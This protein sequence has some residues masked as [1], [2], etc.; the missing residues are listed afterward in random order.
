MRGLVGQGQRAGVLGLALNRP[1]TAV[2][3]TARHGEEVTHRPPRRTRHPGRR[4]GA[5]ADAFDAAPP[6]GGEQ[7]A[8]TVNGGSRPDRRRARR[9]P[10]GACS[11]RR[12]AWGEGPRRK[13]L[14]SRCRRQIA[15]V[16]RPSPGS[17]TWARA[18]KVQI[19]GSLARA[20][21]AARRTPRHRRRPSHRPPA[22]PGARGRA[23][24]RAR[25]PPRPR[26][27]WRTPAAA[28]APRCMQASGAR[29][30][31]VGGRPGSRLA[32]ALGHGRRSY[33]GVGGGIG[34]TTFGLGCG[35]ICESLFQW[36]WVCARVH[37]R[38][39]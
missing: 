9:A 18:A 36:A 31:G 22:A 38:A 29:R 21:R 6:S 13:P 28:R 12:W 5:Q 10:S 24:S 39:H 30:A 15:A 32:T 20:D 19:A 7:A 3:P 37:G 14:H 25:G 34:R 1:R 2:T 27:R 23:A 11:R 33:A 4:P 26:R 8:T 17:C 35:L 16:D